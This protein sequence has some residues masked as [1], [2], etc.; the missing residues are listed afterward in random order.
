[1]AQVRLFAPPH[2]LYAV[3]NLVVIDGPAPSSYCG[4]HFFRPHCVLPPQSHVDKHRSIG[5][6]RMYHSLSDSGSIAEYVYVSLVPFAAVVPEVVLN[7][8]LPLSSLRSS[9][10]A[11]YRRRRRSPLGSDL[12]FDLLSYFVFCVRHS[13]GESLDDVRVLAQLATVMTVRTLYGISLCLPF[14]GKTNKSLGFLPT[15]GAV[16]KCHLFP[17]SR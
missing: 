10:L 4:H 3:R 5:A 14:G 1:M 15:D 6:A 9:D 11:K 17:A 16:C 2:N 12:W 8:L 13:A 7:N